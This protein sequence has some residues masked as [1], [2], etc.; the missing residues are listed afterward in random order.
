MALAVKSKELPVRGMLPVSMLDWDGKLAAVL[1]VGGCNFRCPF[2]HNSDLV[3]DSSKTV[4]VEWNE[5]SEHLVSKREWLDGVVITGGE[6]TIYE[7]LLVFLK[8]IKDLGLPV[9]LDTNGALP[10]ALAEIVKEELVKYVAMDIKTSFGKYALATNAKVDPAVIKESAALIREAG[11]DYEF[12][13]T[14]VP[15]IV[16]PEDVLEIAEILAGANAYYLQQFKPDQVLEPQAIIPSRI[17]GE[18][19]KSCKGI[20]LKDVKP[21]FSEEIEQ[22]ARECSKFLPTKVRSY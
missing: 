6:P 1:F 11:V 7:E 16:N 19:G 10:G 22:M 13:T 4:L 3:K 2:C 8:Q 18:K 15:G 9:K 17:S 12:R 20:Y 14:L 21:Y 5:I